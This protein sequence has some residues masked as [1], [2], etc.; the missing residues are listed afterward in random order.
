MCDRM[1]DQSPALGLTAKPRHKLRRPGFPLPL[2]SNSGGSKNVFRP[3]QSHQTRLR[4]DRLKLPRSSVVVTLNGASNAWNA[5]SFM[6]VIGCPVFVGTSA[7][8]WP[9][10][11]RHTAYILL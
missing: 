10:P 3:F 4:G 5:L 1:S 7:T 6:N 11:T 8:I 2:G 9:A